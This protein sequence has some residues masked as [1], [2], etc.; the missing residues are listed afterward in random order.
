MNKLKVLFFGQFTI[1]HDYGGQG[2]AFP[3]M[4]YLNEYYDAEY[5]FMISD[6]FYKDNIE[7]AKRKGFNIVKFPYP[8]FFRN[9]GALI[10]AV[11]NSDVIIDVDGI[12]FI[13]DKPLLKRW[14]HYFRVNYMHNLA[15]KYNKI[16]LKSPKSYGPFPTGFFRL[17]VKK[18]LDKLPFVLVRGEQNAKEVRD[19]KLK[20]PVY[21]FPDVSLILKPEKREWA[22]KYLKNLGLSMNKEIIG[23]SPSYVINNNPENNHLEFCSEVINYFKSQ[24]KQVLII[25]HAINDGNDIHSCDLALGKYIYKNLKDKANVFLIT[26]MNLEYKHVRGIIGLLSFYITG[27]YHGLASSLYMGIPTVIL[28]WH[29]KYS[30]MTSLF[31]DELPVID[32]GTNAQNALELMRGYYKNQKWFNRTLMAKRKKEVIQNINKALNLMLEEIKRKYGA[33]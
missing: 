19:L 24:G 31:L 28:S 25:P 1:N 20:V 23:I 3:I 9:N 5:T 15:R 7:F 6:K 12:E 13:G 14:F 4:D 29:T 8:Q 26:D 27:R 10:S 17:F 30:D 33:K 16:Y 22:I 32:D 21:S 18:T 2:L 11:K